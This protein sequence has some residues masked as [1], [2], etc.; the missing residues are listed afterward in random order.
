[1]LRSLS[2]VDDTINLINNIR[3]VLS[4]GSFNLT[5]FM[6]ND[7]HILKHVEG[8]S[9]ANQVYEITPDTFSKALGI[10]WDVCKDAFLYSHK[11]H[12]VNDFSGGV[13][14]RQ[15]LSYVS[16]LYDPVGWIS[17]VIFQG[18]MLFQESTRCKLEWDERV[19][20][21]LETK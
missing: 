5:K 20:S 11:D 21:F 19:P 7:N 16:S 18:K 12:C 17:P 13:S 3:P 14:R 4:Y 15:R 10:S 8:E 6:A 2:N 1:M 9:F